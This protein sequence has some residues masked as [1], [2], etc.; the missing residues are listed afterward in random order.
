MSQISKTAV[1]LL[2]RTYKWV[3]SPIFPPACRYVPTCSH[4][5]IEAVEAY[6]T[7]R[8]GWMSVKR[9]L[10][11]H[12]LSKSGYDPVVKPG[13]AEAV[14]GVASAPELCGH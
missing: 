14:G 6:G 7:L 8:G 1:L 2:L 5:A 3:I 4:Y 9:V 12:P 13:N 11:C 10:R